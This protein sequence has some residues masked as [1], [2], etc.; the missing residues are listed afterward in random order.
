MVEAA[1]VAV[2]DAKEVPAAKIPTFN[3]TAY[4]AGHGGHIAII[5]MNTMKAPTAVEKDRIVLAEKGKKILVTGT[6]SGDVFK[7]DVS[8]DKKEG[9]FKVGEKF[10]GTI[11]GPDG[12]IYLE[13][14]ANGDVY[15]WDAKTIR[16]GYE[17]L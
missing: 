15:V 4:I 11:L 9:P 6:L 12:N 2:I 14:M 8:T 16:H 1:N 3:A 17:E 5:D 13:D 10:C 7:I